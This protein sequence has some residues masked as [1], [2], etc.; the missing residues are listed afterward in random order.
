ME[1][2]PQN[3]SRCLRVVLY[4]PESTGKTTL[5]KAL[6][7]HY[8]T[9]WVPEFARSYLQEKWD[10]QQAVCTLAD[11]PIIAQGQLAAENTAIAQANRLIFCDTNILVTKVWS[12]THFEG[13]CAPELNTIL[14]QTHY[15]LYLLTSVDVPWEKDDLRDRPNDREQMFI[16][17]KQ[18]LE[19]YNFPFLVL[20]GSLEERI[21]KAVNTIDQLLDINLTK[22]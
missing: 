14:A 7:D 17:F 18:Q 22:S 16:Y 10:K 6:A 20:E 8:Q 9:S 3:S 2:R 1:T 5:A 19:A 13:Y 12:E 21:Q 11:L 15:D 4:G